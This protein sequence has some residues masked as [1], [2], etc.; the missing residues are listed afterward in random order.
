MAPAPTDGICARRLL[1]VVRNLV[2]RRILLL[3]RSRTNVTERREQPDYFNRS[4]RH[5]NVTAMP[6]A[7]CFEL[8]LAHVLVAAVANCSL[9]P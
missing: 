8:P 9:T 2:S 3:Y 1:H 4:E 6:R 7:S 5:G